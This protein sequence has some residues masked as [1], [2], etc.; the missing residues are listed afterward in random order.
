MKLDITDAMTVDAAVERETK[1]SPSA[2][3]RVEVAYCDQL[4]SGS[5]CPNSLTAC[6][7]YPRGESLCAPPVELVLHVGEVTE[8]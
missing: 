8:R 7:F 5:A 6:C 1:T 3:Q 2:G 4:E